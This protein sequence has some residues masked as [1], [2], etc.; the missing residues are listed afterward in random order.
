MNHA[1]WLSLG[2]SGA[3]AVVAWT[4]GRSARRAARLRPL[5]V[6]PSRRVRRGR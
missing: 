6:P 5:V 3:L 1:V 4:A 2:A